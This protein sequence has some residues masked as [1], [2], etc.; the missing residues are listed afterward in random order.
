[1]NTN[2]RHGI[3]IA[4]LSFDRS[5]YPQG[6]M[7]QSSAMLADG[8]RRARLEKVR[9]PALIL[10]GDLDPLVRPA[11]G[12]AIA[13]ALPDAQ[14]TIFPDWGHGLDYPKLWPV[15]VEHLHVFERKPCH[16]PVGGDQTRPY[17]VLASFIPL[18][19]I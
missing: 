17:P 14:I 7:R 8:N 3:E 10:H 4:G 1:M 15:F 16:E 2:Y 5:F 19:K 6:F 18:S 13:D 12:Q 11:H 9:L